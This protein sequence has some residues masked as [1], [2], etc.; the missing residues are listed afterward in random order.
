MIERAPRPNNQFLLIR[1]D[2][3]R[4]GRLSYRASGVLADILSRPDNWK[5]SAERLAAARPDKEGVK[6]I[7]TVLRELEECGY[8]RRR[9][10]R[11]EQGRFRWVQT[12]YDV[13]VTSETSPDPDVSAGRTMRPKPPGGNDPAVSA[14]LKKT[15]KKDLEEDD[16]DL[17]CSVTS[18]RFAPSG[19]GG[20]TE[21]NFVSDQDDEGRRIDA[22]TMNDWRQQDRALFSEIVGGAL[23]SEGHGRWGKGRWTADS[24]YTAFRKRE[25]RVRWPGRLLQ[26]LDEQGGC[27]VDD[28][29]LDEGLE[30]AI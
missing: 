7:R 15:N 29:L 10:V 27:A 4:D 25:K 6:A 9:R 2:V 5:T 14:L 19:A 11:D 21:D 13:P 17:I 20:H 16:S 28:W 12:I 22:V 23:T 18:S 1:N 26:R 8:L 30:R 24:F 3:A